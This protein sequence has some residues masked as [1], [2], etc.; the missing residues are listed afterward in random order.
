MP[1][2]ASAYVTTDTP[3]RYISRLC[4]HYAHKIPVSFDE[5]HGRIEFDS[6][7]ALLQAEADGLR[8]SVQSTSS[9]G[10]ESLKQVVSRHFERFAWQAESDSAVAAGAPG[11]EHVS[12]QTIRRPL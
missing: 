8:L 4:K 5:Q 3:A 12:R 11:F 6:G 9:E 1:L 7:L 2:I 10:L